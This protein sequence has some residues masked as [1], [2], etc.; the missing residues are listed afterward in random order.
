[1]EMPQLVRLNQLTLA[2]EQAISDDDWDSLPAL[3]AARDEAIEEVAMN[4]LHEDELFALRIADARCSRILQ[5]HASQLLR[6]LQYAFERKRASAAYQQI[7]PPL[8]PMVE[9]DC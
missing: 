2:I 7:A 3:L 1:M 8:H 9:T 4:P 5:D 6:D